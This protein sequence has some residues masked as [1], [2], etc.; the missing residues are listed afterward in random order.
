[1]KLQ[2]R[3]AQPDDAAPML[4]VLNPII[5]ARVY[6]AMDTTYTVESQR[7]YIASY[8]ERGIFLV[9]IREADDR[10]V[11]FQNVEPFAVHG[12]AF[13]HVGVMGTYVDL[14]CRRQ[15]I[16]TRL[17]ETTFAAA[18]A[19]GYEKIFTYVRADN[20]AGIKTYLRHGFEIVG[21]AKRQAKID[22]RYIDELMIE[23][24]LTPAQR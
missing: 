23:R 12:H 5:E 14:P 16:A 2:I 7:D 8:P 19:L 21:T 4:Q 11:G 24:F 13:D 6:T 17:F 1:M 18:P 20:E 3:E 9:A 15:G 10:L 22:G